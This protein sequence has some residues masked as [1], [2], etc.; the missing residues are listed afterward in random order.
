MARLSLRWLLPPDVPPDGVMSL[1]DHLRELRYRIVFSL[2]II[3]GGVAVCLV[4]YSQLYAF[5]LEPYNRAT[6]ALSETHPDIVVQ[7]TLQGVTSPLMLILQM[8][9][10]GGLV[11]TSPLWLYQVWAYL[12]PALLA[13]EKKYALAFLGAAVPLFLLGVTAAYLILPQAMVVLIGFTPD[14]QNIVNLLALNE[15]LTLMLKLMLVFGIG[16]L[17][18]VVVVALNFLGIVPATSLKKARPYVLFGCAV[19]GAAA[20]PGGDPFSMLALALPMML[21]FFVA[22]LIARANDKRRSLRAGTDVVPA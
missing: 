12:A 1:G 19:F 13:K 20:T 3:L 8:V 6:A 17:L 21:L 10:M 22:E 16:F 9:G 14:N 7:A 5:M 11:L 2:V 4:F 18:P 15:F